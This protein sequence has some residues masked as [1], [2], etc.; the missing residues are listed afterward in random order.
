MLHLKAK[1]TQTPLRTGGTSSQR[2]DRPALQESRTLKGSFFLG[3]EA[4]AMPPL[5][6]VRCPLSAAALEERR[7]VTVTSAP[8]V[9]RPDGE[10]S[11]T[12]D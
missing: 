5:A 11:S 9:Q 4:P 8:E 10:P 2:A 6:A 12:A 1:N 7:G 3:H